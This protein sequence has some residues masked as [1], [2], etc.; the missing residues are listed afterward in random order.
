[1]LWTCTLRFVLRLP[2]EEWNAYHSDAG[3]H[4]SKDPG[5]GAFSQWWNRTTTASHDIQA[6]SEFFV[7]YGEPWFEGRPHLGPI[8][9]THDLKRAERL[10]R[11]YVGVRNTTSRRGVDVKLLDE[12]WDQFVVHTSF[13][14]SRVFGAFNHSDKEELPRLLQGGQNLTDI[15]LEQSRR[16]I[17]WLEQHG[18]VRLHFPSRGLR[19]CRAE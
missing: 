17:E 8:P 16:S 2:P 4:R 6:G 14:K 3:L 11:G 13:N 7:S 9:L 12:V 5:A 18:T 1:L 15:R 10:W 19:Y